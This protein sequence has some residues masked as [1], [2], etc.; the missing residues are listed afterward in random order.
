MDPTVLCMEAP[1]T[2]LRADE[3]KCNGFGRN[4]LNAVDMLTGANEIEPATI[5]PSNNRP[6]T[7]EIAEIFC[8]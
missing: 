2:N 4:P 3:A 7:Q 5:N 1:F 6:T 8:H